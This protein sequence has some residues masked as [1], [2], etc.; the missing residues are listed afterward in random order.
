[1]RDEGVSAAPRG[2]QAVLGVL[3]PLLAPV[4]GCVQWLWSAVATFSSMSR[5]PGAG[6]LNRKPQRGAAAQRAHQQQALA[7]MGNQKL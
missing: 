3:C 7:Q 5:G 2:V 4:K 6:W 1:M